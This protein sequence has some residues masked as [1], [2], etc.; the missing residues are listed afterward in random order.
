MALG[1]CIRQ[2]LALKGIKQTQLAKELGVTVSAVYNKF[3]RDSWT[4]KDL[5]KVC[6]ILGCKPA[7]V[8]P[9]GTQ[10]VIRED[11]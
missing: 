1:N 6:D 4:V 2:A 11:E 10:I 5:I 9:D 8:F 7:F 3:V